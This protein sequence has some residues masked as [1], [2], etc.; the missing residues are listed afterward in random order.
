M[1][2][3]LIL[4]HG[5][6]KINSLTKY[7]SILTLH[8]IGEK[9]RLTNELTTDL[10]GEQMYATEKIDG[11]NVRLVCWGNEYLIGSREF[12]LHYCQD[13]YF[14]TAQGIVE[15]IKELKTKMLSTNTLTVVYGELFGGKMSSNSKQ[16]G[17]EKLGFRVFDI[18][19]FSDLS[20]LDQNLDEISR[21]RE[22]ETAKGIIYGQKFFNNDELSFYS[23]DF[24]LVPS[25]KFD[26]GDYS[27]KTILTNLY[28]YLPETQVALSS[29]ALKRPEGLVLRNHNR[30]KI[31]KLRFEDYERTLK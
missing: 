29:S 18:A 6:L 9:G 24:Q 3:E 12:V 11:T 21:W 5:K 28:Q 1:L 15:G 31:V 7:P 4:K 23:N 13:L 19:Q 30:S 25:V 16:Y 26:L 14:D 22:Y 20:I 2:K 27:H 10:G 17:T 8:K